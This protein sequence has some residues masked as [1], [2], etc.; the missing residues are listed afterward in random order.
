M[1]QIYTLGFLATTHKNALN[2]L[3]KVVLL[4]QILY[5]YLILMQQISFTQLINGKHIIN[6]LVSR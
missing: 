6:T 4:W 3:V 1:V 5:R 2:K